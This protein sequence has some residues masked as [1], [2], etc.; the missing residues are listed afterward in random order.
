MASKLQ[1]K[2][3]RNTSQVGTEKTQNGIE[4]QKLTDMHV[5]ETWLERNNR[6]GQP[7]SNQMVAIRTSMEMIGKRKLAYHAHKVLV[8][9]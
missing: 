7:I 4:R 2:P 3:F 9:K 5:W 6:I 1:S 8:T